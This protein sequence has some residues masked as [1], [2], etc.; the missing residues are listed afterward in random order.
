MCLMVRPMT[1]LDTRCPA[2]GSTVRILVHDPRLEILA[3]DRTCACP[4]RE[5]ALVLVD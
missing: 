5:E 2:C 1:V 4:M 3:V